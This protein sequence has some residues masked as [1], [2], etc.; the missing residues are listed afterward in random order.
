MNVLAKFSPVP[1][2]IGVSKKFGQ[3]LDTLSRSRSPFSEIV[4][5]VLWHMLTKL[6]QES[7]RV[8]QQ[9]CATFF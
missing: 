4:N 3:S 7:Y 9:S 1:E 2:I 6:V 8:L 5:D